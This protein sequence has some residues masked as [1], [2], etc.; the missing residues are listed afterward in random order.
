MTVRAC[1]MQR[2]RAVVIVGLVDIDAALHQ[3]LHL[4]HITNG[5]QDVELSPGV[6][7]RRTD[8]GA[9]FREQPRARLTALPACGVQR[10]LAIVVGLVDVG[11]T[12]HL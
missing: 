11:A 3:R 7:T 12:F 2:R 5:T 8:V 1:H 9:A 4:L 10:R 6:E